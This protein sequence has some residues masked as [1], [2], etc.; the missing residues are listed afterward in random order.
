MLRRR[1]LLVAHLLVPSSGPREL[2][3]PDNTGTGSVRVKPSPSGEGACLCTVYTG[4]TGKPQAIDLMPF[5][6]GPI[7]PVSITENKETH[8]A[9]KLRVAGL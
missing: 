2:H 1:R 4:R 5:P 3:V 9:K 7:Q 8:K 6:W